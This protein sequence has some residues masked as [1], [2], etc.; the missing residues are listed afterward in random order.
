MKVNE[1][2]S[3]ALKGKQSNKDRHTQNQIEKILHQIKSGV[4]MAPLSFFTSASFL[5]YSLESFISC[6]LKDPPYH[7]KGNS[8]VTV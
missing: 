4:R 3:Q 5:S 1:A 8:E 2:Q 6:L 7:L